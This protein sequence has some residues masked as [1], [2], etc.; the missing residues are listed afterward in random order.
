[1]DGLPPFIPPGGHA[2]AGS[3]R[4]LRHHYAA[5]VPLR[6]AVKHGAAAALMQAND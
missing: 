5:V 3:V 1:M 4:G 6:F 2:P